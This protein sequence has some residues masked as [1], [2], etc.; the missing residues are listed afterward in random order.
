MP[1]EQI[2]ILHKILTGS[3]RV[4]VSATLVTRALAEAVERDKAELTHRLMGDFPTTP[5]FF[6]SLAEGLGDGPLPSQPYPFLLA[7]PVELDAVVNEGLRSY[8]VEWKWDGVRSQVVK[9]AG[10]VFLW[11]RGEDL[12]TAQFPQVAEAFLGTAR[13]H[14]ARR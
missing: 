6:R 2:F 8:R 14:R 1:E 13:R 11:S 9:R 4:G 7:Y 3:F 12:V 5:E 10:E